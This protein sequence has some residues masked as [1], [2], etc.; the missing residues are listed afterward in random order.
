MTG[1]WVFLAKEA[2]EILH[3]WRGK[4][5]LG[6]V[7]FFALSSAPLAL[8]TPAL[9]ESFV[10]TGAMQLQIPDPTFVD[11]YAQWVKNLEQIAMMALIISSGGLVSGELA[12]NTA[13]V[14]LS[15]RLSRPAFVIAKYTAQSLFVV[16]T[17]VLATVLAEVLTLASFGES[18]PMWI[19]G[20]VG[21][22]LVFALAMVAV[23]TFFSSLMS[24]LA[25]GGLGVGAFF[26]VSLGAL[27][28]PLV[29]YSPAG[30]PAMTTALMRGDAV[31]SYWP[32][33]ASALLAAIALVGSVIGFSRREI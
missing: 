6:V 19:A 27:W 18:R 8:F 4:V 2:R 16:S 13:A 21:A 30:V 20:A 33:A 11:A 1:F 5:F 32:L 22:W 15:K 14:V 29:T 17:T 24:P 28:E 9:L 7:L 23:T 3:T 31:D 25:A 12:A 10:D 26:L